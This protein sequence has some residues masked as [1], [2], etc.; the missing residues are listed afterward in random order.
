MPKYSE[1]CANAWHNYSQ[2]KYF[3]N[4]AK[5]RARF[6][7]FITETVIFGSLFLNLFTI[8]DLYKMLKNPF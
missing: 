2:L 6:W 5:T 4:T 1:N 8:W 7:Y 3:G